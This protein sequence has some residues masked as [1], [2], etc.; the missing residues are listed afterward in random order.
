MVELPTID[1]PETTAIESLIPVAS[2][3]K[4]RAA[5]GR[6]RPMVLGTAVAV[7]IAGAYV[8][9]SGAMPAHEAAADNG[10]ITAE[11][12]HQLAVA[13]AGGLGFVDQGPGGDGR[14]L[15]Q[16]SDI[17]T[18]PVAAGTRRRAQA[19]DRDLDRSHDPGP[20]AG[21]SE[22]FGRGDRTRPG[23]RGCL[24]PVGPVG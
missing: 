3:S 9:L 12:V 2:A 18:S 8:G 15:G 20:A 1:Y 21:V 7:L 17:R 5:S 24:G 4:A 13:P 23:G 10:P 6:R 19:P 16:W 22:G 14:D 11:P